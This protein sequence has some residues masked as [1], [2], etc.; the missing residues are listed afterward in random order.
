M[1][2]HEQIYEYIVNR[3]HFSVFHTGPENLFCLSSTKPLWTQF[4]LVKEADFYAA[5]PQC[6]SIWPL[7][8]IR[9][10]SQERR[11]CFGVQMMSV[12]GSYIM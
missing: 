9:Q 6:T 5:H 3:L 8:W 11:V 2:F 4:I 12:L 1:I 7:H 10:M